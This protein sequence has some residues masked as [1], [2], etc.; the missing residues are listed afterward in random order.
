MADSEGVE[1]HSCELCGMVY[2]SAERL[3]K[4][5][6][7]FC[8]GSALHRALLATREEAAGSIA[9]AL[10]GVERDGSQSTHS[11]QLVSCCLAS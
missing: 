1:S 10:E 7:N 3:T 4:H 9:T 2:T 8:Q 5:R 6:L 11:L